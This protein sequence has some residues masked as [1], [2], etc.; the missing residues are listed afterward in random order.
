MYIYLWLH[1]GVSGCLFVQFVLVFEEIP[2]FFLGVL[3]VEL[4]YYCLRLAFFFFL[5]RRLGVCYFSSMTWLMSM[6]NAFEVYMSYY[7]EWRTC[8]SS[9][10]FKSVKLRINFVILCVTAPNVACKNLN[11]EEGTLVLVRSWNMVIW[12]NF[13]YISWVNYV[14]WRFQQWILLGISICWLHHWKWVHGSH[15][16]C[17]VMLVSISANNGHVGFSLW[18]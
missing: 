13:C 17:M 10:S 15:Y 12:G 4:D 14:C 16:F 18:E 5:E 11:L 2:F 6:L 9:T 7:V 3:L 1:V 8:G